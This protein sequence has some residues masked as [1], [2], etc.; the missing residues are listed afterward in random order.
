MTVG[1]LFTC[2]WGIVASIV[3]ASVALAVIQTAFENYKDTGSK[4]APGKT[5]LIPEA[6]KVSN[7]STLLLCLGQ[8]EMYSDLNKRMDVHYLML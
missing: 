8:N 5:H 6:G 3:G 2:R 7:N 4:E 1:E